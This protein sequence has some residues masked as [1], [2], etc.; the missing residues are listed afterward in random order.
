MHTTTFLAY[1]KYILL[2]TRKLVRNQI[3]RNRPHLMTMAV[4]YTIALTTLDVKATISWS[5]PVDS[6]KKSNL[7]NTW[8]RQDMQLQS[9]SWPHHGDYV[10]ILIP[11]RHFW[12]RTKVSFHGVKSYCCDCIYFPTWV[13]VNRFVIDTS[14]F[15]IKTKIVRAF[16]FLEWKIILIWLKRALIYWPLIWQNQWI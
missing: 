1:M 6:L 5:R 12:P 2:G 14:M 3:S 13:T 9:P 8:Y 16:A 15:N 7:D 11:L 10:V 4:I